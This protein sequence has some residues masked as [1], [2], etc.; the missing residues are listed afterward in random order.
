MPKLNSPGAIRV[1]AVMAKLKKLKCDPIEGLA[2]IAMG[3]V[4]SL[5]LMSKKELDTPAWTSKDGI[6]FSPSGKEKAEKLIPVKV[7]ADC[8]MELLRYI[9]PSLKTVDAETGDSTDKTVV[10]IYIP[11]NGRGTVG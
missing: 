9:A 11:D 8:Y 4:I 6:E 1:D 7:R 2:K 3:D 5:G 10:Q